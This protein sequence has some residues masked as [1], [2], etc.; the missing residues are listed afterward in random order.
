MRQ[1]NTFARRIDE[2]IN[3]VT[4]V[5]GQTLMELLD[6]IKAARDHL[7]NLETQLS[8]HSEE[9]CATVSA[10]IRKLLPKVEIN[11]SDSRCMV[12]YKARSIVIKPDLNKNEFKILPGPTQADARLV[13]KF[14]SK[15]NG[16]P[17][18]SLSDLAYDAALLFVGNYK[19]LQ[20]GRVT[21]EK[22]EKEEVPEESGTFDDGTR[23]PDLGSRIEGDD[24]GPAVGSAI[25]RQGVSKTGGGSQ[26]S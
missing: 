17:I 12:K 7:E 24:P 15:W 9:I 22:K 25:K 2:A 6:E 5:D 1:H 19:T 11:L 20:G 3:R 4:G 13:K 18:D 26:Y 21:P 14:A 8:D 23:A 10:E 16:S